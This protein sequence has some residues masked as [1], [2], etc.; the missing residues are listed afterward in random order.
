M[1]PW[2]AHVSTKLAG[3]ASSNIFWLHDLQRFAGW[4]WFVQYLKKAHDAICFTNV[5]AE[6]V[7]DAYA[8]QR[9]VVFNLAGCTADD[10]IDHVLSYIRKLKA[11]GPLFCSM[12]GVLEFHPPHVIVFADFP[13]PRPRLLPA[14]P[15]KAPVKRPLSEEANEKQSVE[16]DIPRPEECNKR[17]REAK[18]PKTSEE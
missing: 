6:G 4:Q 5:T 13:I 8:F 15:G 16:P 1:E 10:N 12:R 2:Q 11:G 18:G 14:K 3:P 7:A 17:P 9:V